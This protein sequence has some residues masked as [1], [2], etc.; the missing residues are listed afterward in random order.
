[1]ITISKQQAAQFIFL[2]QGLIGAFRTG[3]PVFLRSRDCGGSRECG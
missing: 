3:R 2:K 1:M